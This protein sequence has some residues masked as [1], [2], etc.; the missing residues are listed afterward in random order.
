MDN[1]TVWLS[2]EQISLL[3]DKSISTI[4]EHIKNILIEELDAKDV[5]NKFGKTEFSKRPINVYNLDMILAIG[6]RVNS[7]RG[8]LFRKWASAI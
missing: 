2:Q 4:N 6:Y 8:I 7:K 5:R 1:D 3:F